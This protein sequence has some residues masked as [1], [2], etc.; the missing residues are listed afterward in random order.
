MEFYIA[1]ITNPL[2]KAICFT[3]A[4][5]SVFFVN[6]LEL[7]GLS[8]PAGG[9]LDCIKS[10]IEVPAPTNG[11]ELNEAISEFEKQFDSIK[12]SQWLDAHSVSIPIVSAVPARFFSGP[13]SSI[14]K[15]LPPKLEKIDFTNG[16][17]RLDI[18]GMNLQQLGTFWVDLQ[19]KKVIKSVVDGQEMDLN[20]GEPFAEP[21]K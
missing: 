14:R 1:A 21:L 8:D 10:Y 20:T 3:D 12:L 5:C 4:R 9:Y 19:T 13:N 18:K 17:M 16:V 7:T 2:T 6:N 15:S 11:L